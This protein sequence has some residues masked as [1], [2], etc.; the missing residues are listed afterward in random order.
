MGVTAMDVNTA[1][2]TVRVVEP[3]TAPDVA[4][5]VELPT[6]VPVASPAEV[7]VAALVF[8]EV[9]VT[10]PVRF[11]VL[12]SLKV[13][14]AVNCCVNPFAIEGLAGVTAIDVNT[15]AVTAR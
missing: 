12:L 6:P 4:R 9:Q 14:V 2:V 3:V 10:V 11:C 5:M 7:I 13:P 8:V 1:A 15:A